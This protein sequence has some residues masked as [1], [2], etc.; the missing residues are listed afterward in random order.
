MEAYFKLEQKNIF[1][2]FT[3]VQ[4]YFPLTREWYGKAFENEFFKQETKLST[5]ARM[6]P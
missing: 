1:F 5:K 2:K 4:V 6:E 3:L